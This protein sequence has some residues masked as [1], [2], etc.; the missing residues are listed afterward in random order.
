MEVV[1]LLWAELYRGGR[2]YSR[3]YLV[4]CLDL[5]LRYAIPVL[6]PEPSAVT[7]ALCCAIIAWQACFCSLIPT[8]NRFPS[9]RAS[10]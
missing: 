8:R 2:C 7:E 6:V 9:S 5:R 10:L 4:W 3:L 1:S